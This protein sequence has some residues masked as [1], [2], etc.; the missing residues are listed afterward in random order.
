MYAWKAMKEEWVEKAELCALKFE[1]GISIEKVKRD[2]G[3]TL[4]VY[5]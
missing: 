1:S 2:N 3:H 5:E 4:Y